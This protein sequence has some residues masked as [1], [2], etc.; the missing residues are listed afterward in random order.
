MYAYLKG[1]LV[2]TTPLETIV[3]VQG[4][5][6]RLWVSMKDFGRLPQIGEKIQLYTSFIVRELSHTLYGFLI[7]EERDLFEELIAITGIGPK[8]GLSILGHLSVQELQEAVYGHDSTCLAKVPGIGK[9]TAERLLIELQGRFNLQTISKKTKANGQISDAL[10]ALMQ[11]GYTQAAAE[12]AVKKAAD[13]LESGYDLSSL[14]TTA[15]KYR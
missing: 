6:Y 2:D 12:K 3:E 7:K 15:L 14:I 13:A 10:Q 11:L 4:I 5:G 1:T 9:K 8:T